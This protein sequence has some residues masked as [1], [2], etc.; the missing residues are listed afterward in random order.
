MRVLVA[1]LVVLSVSSMAMAYADLCTDPGIQLPQAGGYAKGT[2]NAWYGGANVKGSGASGCTTQLWGTGA[3]SGGDCALVTFSVTDI[4]AAIAATLSSNPNW[5][6]YL[7]CVPKS[8][9]TVGGMPVAGL[10]SQPNGVNWAATDMLGTQATTGTSWDSTTTFEAMA[11]AQGQLVGG[12][13][14]HFTQQAYTFTGVTT[15]PNVY[16]IHVG[17]AMVDAY[18]NNTGYNWTGFFLSNAGASGSIRLNTGEQWSQGAGYMDLEII[19]TPEPATLCLL[20]MGG[21]ALLRRRS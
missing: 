19:G 9:G 16:R 13:G 18:R 12:D 15:V 5:D 11:T 20:A 4:N 17:K 7:L 1:L 2:W 3:A 21:L 10:F 6:A 8:T 14:T